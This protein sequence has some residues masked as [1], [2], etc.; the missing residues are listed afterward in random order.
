MEKII[1]TLL[2]AEAIALCVELFINIVLYLKLRPEKSKIDNTLTVTDTFDKKYDIY[3]VSG[4]IFKCAEPVPYYM[5]FRLKYTSNI[6]WG[7]IT[8]TYDTNSNAWEID[9]EYMS[10]EFCKAVLNKWLYDTYISE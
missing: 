1:L 6:G 3:E 9:D 8:F 7:E 4:E 2:V 10:E 5:V